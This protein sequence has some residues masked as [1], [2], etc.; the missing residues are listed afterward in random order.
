MTATNTKQPNSADGERGLPTTTYAIL[1]LLTFGETSGYDLAKLVDRSVGFFWSP[2]KS[3]IYA[4]LRRLVSLGFAT[5]REVE[6]R[7]R[8]DKRLYR[9][10][11]RGTR[12]LR[13]WLERA[14]EE[15][16]SVKSQFLVKV[17]FGHLMDRGTFV[18]RMREYR[19]QA[20][21]HLGTLRDVE[22][23]IR[24]DP[25]AAFPYLVLR[26]GLQH[27]RATIRWID[28]VLRQVAREGAA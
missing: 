23:Q 22:R 27:A 8:P 14:D 24:D 2:A 12:A 25:E 5:E 7:D 15:P 28:E 16:E 18:R 11:D 17:F 21:A 6:Q 9:I 3:Q 4:E 26:A 10:T 13:S 19:T 1:G 20:E